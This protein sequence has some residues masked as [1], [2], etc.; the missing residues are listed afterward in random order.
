MNRHRKILI[1][2]I[3]IGIGIIAILAGASLFLGAGARI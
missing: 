3:I 1:L 2:G